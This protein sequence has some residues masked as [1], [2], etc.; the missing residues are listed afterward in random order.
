VYYDEEEDGEGQGGAEK[1]S[2]SVA[3]AAAAGAAGEA[4]AEAAG[5]AAG[6][7][8][9]T[10]AAAGSDA[11]VERGGEGPSP[12]LA[13]PP[14]G[15]TPADG[16]SP[17]GGASS[18]EPDPTGDGASSAGDNADKEGMDLGTA[19]GLFQLTEHTVLWGPQHDAK[20]LIGWSREA[21]TVVVCFRGTISMTNML[22]NLK[23]G[24]AGLR[25]GW[26]EMRW[27]DYREGC[28]GRMVHGMEF[29]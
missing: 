28:E 1:S 17:A 22:Q 19:L 14:A 11:D 29:L 15:A 25:G 20:C 8:A 21:G 5:E 7:A 18:G 4:D 12:A 27:M 13:P 24:G 9:A 3:G 10:V 16:A 2:K 6:K 26:D 23:V